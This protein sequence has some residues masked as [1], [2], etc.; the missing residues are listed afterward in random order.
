MRLFHP[1]LY[2]IDSVEIES[3]IARYVGSVYSLILGTPQLGI[4]VKDVI[5]P[6]FERVDITSADLH[7]GTAGGQ[8]PDPSICRHMHIPLDKEDSSECNFTLAVFVS[9]LA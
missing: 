1:I 5:S 2:D 4:V 6:P 9:E 8:S 3:D 7:P